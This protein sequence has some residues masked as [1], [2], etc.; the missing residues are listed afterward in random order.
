MKFLTIAL[1]ILFITL[2]G[3]TQAAGG[4]RNAV[5][6]EE[7]MP[8]VAAALEGK[9]F[10]G[11]LSFEELGIQ[12][13]REAQIICGFILNLVDALP[14]F[15]TCSC[16]I[17]FF[18]LRI[19]FGCAAEVCLPDLELVNILNPICLVP[20]YNGIMRLNGALTSTICNE[21]IEISFEVLG[22][23][24]VLTLPKTCAVGEHVPL[25]FSQLR[26]CE[27]SIGDYACPCSVCGSS[28]SVT[29]DCTGA[30]SILGPLAPLAIFTCI[31]LDVVGGRRGGRRERGIGPFISP[32]LSL[33][34][35][36]AQP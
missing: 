11:E 34:G 17:Q 2:L 4:I 8:K 14:D 35:L 26:G 20:S 3:T 36:L 32:I 15:V 27:F 24:V 25:R 31:G 6:E 28:R 1:S 13:E 10:S 18:Q 30:T 19:L 5:A 9:D 21:E 33:P 22:Q 7:L 12:D 29:I 16:N 23:P